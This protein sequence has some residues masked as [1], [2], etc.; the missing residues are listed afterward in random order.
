MERPSTT[1]TQSSQSSQR[2]RREHSNQTSKLII[3]AAIDV[4][5]KLGPGL[6]ESVYQTCT[7]HYL[8][9]ANQKVLTEVTLPVVYRD[10]VLQPGFRIDMLVNDCVIAELKS[11]E[12]LLPIH[13][14]QLLSYFRLS[15]MR[16]GLLINFNV[17]RLIMGVKRI[18][19][20]F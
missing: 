5:S 12:Q 16:L 2:L 20:N 8:R 3:S 4:H 18:V 1:S 7:A 13:Y 10:V 9:E 6:L 15:G 14:A 17:P 11:V 19:N